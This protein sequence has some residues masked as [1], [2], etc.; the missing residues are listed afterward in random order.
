[1]SCSS[2]KKMRKDKRIRITNAQAEAESKR[3]AA[4]GDA[5]ATRIRG[6]GEAA[7]LRAINAAITP[8]TTQ[9]TIAQ[10][11]DGKVPQ[12]VAGNSGAII[13]VPSP[14]AK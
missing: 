9:Y 10:K 5:D 2:K 11:W 3:I 8:E 1:M 13:S 7:R 14:T 4:Q 6:E 12:I